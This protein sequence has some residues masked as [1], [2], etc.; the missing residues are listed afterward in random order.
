MTY[1]PNYEGKGI[2]PDLVVELS[3][4]AQNKSIWAL[5]DEEDV[6]KTAAINSVSER[7]VSE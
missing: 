7:V 2:T 1:S 5:T 4:E 3:E 6:Q